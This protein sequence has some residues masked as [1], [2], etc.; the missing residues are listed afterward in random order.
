[1]KGLTRS[2]IFLLS[3][4]ALIAAYHFAAAGRQHAGTHVA[5]VPAGRWWPLPQNYGITSGFGEFRPYRFHFG[6]DFSTNGKLGLPV[7]VWREGEIFRLRVERRGYGN[8]VY[9]RHPDGMVTLYAHL[10]RFEDRMLGLQSRVNA[11]RQKT[12]LWYPGDIRLAN[13]IPVKRGSVIGFS[14]ESGAGPPHLHIEFRDGENRP[15]NPFRGVLHDIGD[16]QHPVIQGLIWIPADPG[17]VINGRPGP[18][19]MPLN[20]P[21]EVVTLKNPVVLTG[22]VDLFVAAYD[23]TFRPYRRVPASIMMTLDGELVYRWEPKYVAFQDQPRAGF[24]YDFGR[25]GPKD[26]VIPIRMTRTA[27]APPGMVPKGMQGFLDPTPGLHRLRFVVRDYNGG[28]QTVELRLYR[29]VPPLFHVRTQGS[30]LT[31][32][33]EEA[34]NPN[35]WWV[36][37]RTPAGVWSRVNPDESGNVRIRWDPAE[38]PSIRVVMLIYKTVEFRQALR[39][40]CGNPSE[41][42]PIPTP[43]GLEVRGPDFDV[44]P[45]SEPDRCFRFI[46]YE[47]VRSTGPFSTPG[48]TVIHLRRGERRTIRFGALEWL[49]PPDGLFG[50]ITV[51]LHTV[52]PFKVPDGLVPV[53][54]VYR[55]DS[56]G[57][58]FAHP[59][60]FR[61]RA[62]SARNSRD[63]L[64]LFWYHPQK[65]TWV[66]GGEFPDY[67]LQIVTYH[68]LWFMVARDHAPP[69]FTSPVRITWDPDREPLR[70][71]YQEIGFGLRLDR[72][73]AIWDGRKLIVPNEVDD[74]P[75]YPAIVYRPQTRPAKGDHRLTVV[76]EDWAGHRVRQTFTVRVT[77]P[78]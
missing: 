6:V 11:I 33:P 62:S 56:T 3:V 8:A 48:V 42:L 64:G 53:G 15:V 36:E 9:I 27:S 30:S 61:W 28:S 31:V 40:A 13:L 44:L 20:S 29:A 51:Y 5:A 43:F 65:E 75:D 74:D 72:I 45:C 2:G 50:D 55:I 70:I 19:R 24:V 47:S 35:P 39:P 16:H 37:V 57:I 23:P 22:P 26:W 66:F 71:F 38:C 52:P 68:P 59:H 41:Q 21:D 32:Q 77:E 17:T 73:E 78:P 7:R 60:R 67:P 49:V 46:P 34:S 54:E 14:G 25:R 1:M 4:T 63:P 18:Y 12:G 58:P 10:D 76:I 69:V